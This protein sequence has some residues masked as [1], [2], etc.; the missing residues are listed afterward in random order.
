[1]ENITGIPAIVATIV[2]L[3]IELVPQAQTWWNGYT[4][5]QKQALIAAMVF[6]VTLS[7]AGVNTLVYGNAPGDWLQYVIMLALE[8]VIAASGTQAAHRLSR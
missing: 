2:A 7:V 5:R 4:S 8:F 6:V 1:M 3:I